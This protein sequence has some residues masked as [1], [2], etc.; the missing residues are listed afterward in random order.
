MRP[1]HILLLIL[2]CAIWGAN[3]PAS[4]IA[5][6]HFP[7]IF[8]TVLRF[9]ML[10]LLLVPW[11]KWQP[12]QM[13]RVV[14]ISLFMGTFHFSLI[15]IAVMMARDVSV[16]A[17]VVQLGIPIS[18]L[19]AWLV[20]GE[21]VRWR[22]CLGMALAFSGAVVMSFDPGVFAYAAAVAVALI[23]TISMSVG[24]ILVRRVRDVD[25]MSM[26]A[27][28]GMLSA[29]GLL[30]LSVLFETG[31]VESIV[32]AGWKEW[33]VLIFA[34]VMVSLVGHGGAYTLMRQYPVAVVSP[35]FTLT[36]VFGVLMAM[37]VLDERLSERVMI[38]AAVT[39]VGVLIVNLRESQLADMLPGKRD[40]A[41][42]KLKVGGS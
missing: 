26:Q 34:T 29:P 35:G 12:G 17:V 15:Y 39:L 28:I 38:G 9:S 3:F 40:V 25:A 16:I 37:L 20:L 7:P 21:T 11:L 4:K 2:I 14:A 30:L 5:T 32:S 6:N 8:F 24:Q 42:L 31:Q 18:T 13:R 10:A 19:L 23:S 36:P 41:A 1:R 27:W 22:R 33:G